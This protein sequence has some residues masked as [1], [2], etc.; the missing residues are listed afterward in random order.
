M[1]ALKPALNADEIA[2]HLLMEIPDILFERPT[3]EARVVVPNEAVPPLRLDA[4]VLQQ[5][6]DAIRSATGLQVILSVA[7]P[8]EEQGG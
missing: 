5:V 7:P 8:E 1:T 6:D 3:I 4:E 2:I